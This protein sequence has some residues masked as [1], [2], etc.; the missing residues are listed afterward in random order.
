MDVYHILS[1]YQTLQSKHNEES[2]LITVC[3]T[4]HFGL[5]KF[6]IKTKLYVK[7]NY[8]LLLEV[9]IVWLTL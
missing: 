1:K 5:Y 7:K 8:N 9:Y 4:L 2:Q 3:N 6:K